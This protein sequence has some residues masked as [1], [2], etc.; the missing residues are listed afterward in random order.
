MVSAA[1]CNSGWAI[2]QPTDLTVS[3]THARSHSPRS[4]QE[5]AAATAAADDA[6]AVVELARASCGEQASAT[7]AATAN[8]LAAPALSRALAD[9]L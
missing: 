8:P 7:V 1:C 5:N 2:D 3:L 9:L 4:E 6:R